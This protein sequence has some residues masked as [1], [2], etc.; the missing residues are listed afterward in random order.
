MTGKPAAES[1][2]VPGWMPAVLA[3]AALVCYLT[4]FSGRFIL[5]DDK[6]IVQNQAIQQVSSAWELIA[7]SSR[8]VVSVTLA[9]NYALGG[10]NVWGYHAVNL[11][12]HVLAGL[13]LFA[14]IRRALL[15]QRVRD[16]Y[17]REAS[18]LALVCALL[19]V[20]HPLQT[21]SVTYI[22]Q[23]GE[24]LMGLFY[25]LTLYCLLGGADA[26]RPVWWHVA[27]VAACALGMGSKGVMVTAPAAA[28]IF[29]RIFLADSFASLLRR[30]WGLYLGL[31]ATWL[32]LALTGVAGGVLLPSP[33]A[34]ATAGFGVRSITPLEYAATQPGVIMH[35]LRLAFWPSPLCLDYAWPIARTAGAVLPPLI[36]VG[37]LV[38]ITAW[39]LR[40]RPEVGYL[41]VWFF[42]ILLPTSSFIP[43]QDVAFEHRMY[44]PLAAVIAGSVFAAHWL[45]GRVGLGRSPRIAVGG[46]VVGLVAVVLGYRTLDRNSD[47]QSPERMWRDV[48]ATQPDNPRAWCGLGVILVNQRRPDEAVPHFARAIE[49]AP[50]LAEAQF[51]MGVALYHTGD[52]KGAITHYEKALELQPG[53][54]LAHNNLGVALQDLGPLDEAVNHYREAIRL[55]PAFAD[56]R[57]NLARVLAQR[58][59][60]SEAAS[61]WVELVS[62]HPADVQARFALAH[63]LLAQNRL[64]DATKQLLEL[65]RLKPDWAQVHNSLG[66]ALSRQGRA[67]EAIPHFQEALRLDPNLTEARSSLDQAVGGQPRTAAPVAEAVEGQ[68]PMLTGAASDFARGNLLAA[69]G[70]TAEAIEAFQAALRLDPNHV[71]ARVNLGVMYVRLGRPDEAVAEYR[72]ALALDPGH[73][74]ANYNLGN[75]LAGRREFEEAIAAY[76]RAVERKPEYVEARI[77]LGNLLRGVGRLD[78]SI[79]QHRQALAYEP[80]NV[81][82][83]C[84]LA[85]GLATAGQVTEAL[86]HVERAIELDPDDAGARHLR[87]QILAVGQS[88]DPLP[89]E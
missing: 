26:G 5:D 84:N 76:Q 81:A 50:N 48:L 12:I 62:Q 45:L 57:R 77:N 67:D 74:E 60:L 87:D 59:E 37:A 54:F 68:A 21:Q 42:L 56:A 25:L 1:Q 27:A 29:D 85:V 35:Y 22:I 70:K 41:G 80:D 3:G 55:A 44:L 10:L 6:H 23:R 53:M 89:A 24:S 83:M 49:I 32:V 78:E 69:E 39:A 13:T 79:A 52:L 63:V 72:A 14:V 16:R 46:A 88:T 38:A 58:G 34:P 2:P 82:A 61:C 9:V 28:I 86:E 20:V 51:N 18:W 40:R 4:S 11:T 71:E 64:D 17:G 19:W 36:A 65:L 8:P 31:G 66:T 43:L 15:C 73:A 47:Y 33:G 7:K 30:R 75:A